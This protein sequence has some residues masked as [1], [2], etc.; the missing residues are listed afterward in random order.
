MLG[1]LPLALFARAVQVADMLASLPTPA[2][3]DLAEAHGLHLV[4]T[5]IV[6]AYNEVEG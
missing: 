4:R 5:A 1:P 3:R 2:A 6:E